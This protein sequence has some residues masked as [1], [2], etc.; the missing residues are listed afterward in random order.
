MLDNQILDKLLILI[1][2]NCLAYN[3]CSLTL[4][5]ASCSL[6]RPSVST[7]PKSEFEFTKFCHRAIFCILLL[8]SHIMH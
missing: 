8:L 7:Q 4:L 1:L 2:L 5:L 6:P 3:I